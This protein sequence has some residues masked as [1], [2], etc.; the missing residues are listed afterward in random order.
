MRHVKL[1]PGTG[2]DAAGLSSLIGAAYADI[3]L[4]DSAG[5]NS[6]SLFRAASA[7]AGVSP[8][9]VQQFSPPRPSISEVGT[10]VE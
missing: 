2:V 3:K 7:P 6:L 1:K 4:R 5:A 10:A 9:R 8:E